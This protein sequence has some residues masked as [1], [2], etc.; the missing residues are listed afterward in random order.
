MSNEVKGRKVIPIEDY[1]HLN[2]SGFPCSL[3]YKYRLIKKYEKGI[4]GHPPFDYMKSKN[5][6][7]I[8]VD[9]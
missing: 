5:K 6:I 3:Q 9:T 4:A 1:V 2:R 8:L 7:F